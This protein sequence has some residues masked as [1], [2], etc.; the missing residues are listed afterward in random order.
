MTTLKKA[1]MKND[2]YYEVNEYLRQA[3]IA[4]NRA[5]DAAC[6]GERLLRP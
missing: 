4:V 1:L 2:K 6:P 5:F 3:V